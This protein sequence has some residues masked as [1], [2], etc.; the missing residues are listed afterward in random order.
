MLTVLGSPRR[1]CDGP[2]RRETL[3]AGALSLLGGLGL[4][5]VLRAESGTAA[6]RQRA[7]HVIVVNLLGGAATQDMFDLKPS[8]PAGVRSEFKPI[9]TSAAG[10]QV[11]EHLPRLARWMH[12]AAL[13]RSV[14]HKAGCHNP[15]PSYTGSEQPPPN[16]VSTNDNY[17]PSM[18]S[19][20]EYLRQN[21]QGGPRKV[22]LPD[23]V[24]M[25]CYLGW[26]QAI[27]RPGPYAGFLGQPCEALYTECTPYLDK[28][29]ACL[30][31]QPQY[32]RGQP[33]LPGAALEG[34]GI[35]LDRLNDRRS[36]LHQFESKLPRAEAAVARGGYD[37]QQQRA[38]QLLTSA[39]VR[40]A[41]DLERE[42]P[43][44]R[45][46]YGRTLFGSS[47]LIAR[48]LIEAGVR[49]VNV[50]CR[51][52]TSMQRAGSRRAARRAPWRT[53]TASPGPS[54]RG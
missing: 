3:Q 54:P 43:A 50:T 41:F 40:S 44:L 46:R 38:F 24:Y 5:Q 33:R 52:L 42:P 18:G 8:A 30:P 53:C 9:A 37:R 12:R 29:C 36:L 27:R 20:C 21:G 31:G 4:P 1:L 15:L 13:V 35:T 6:V 10:I 32:V 25:P 2:T 23:Y 34:G 28:G 14:N 49:F 7:K 45:E 16:I 22:D 51:M 26:G 11:C 39:A 17:P 19:V 47:T 48:R